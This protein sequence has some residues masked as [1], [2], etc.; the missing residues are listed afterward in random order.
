MQAL[1]D[2][3]EAAPSQDEMSKVQI[4]DLKD[5][6]AKAEE[7][8]G[9][10]NDEYQHLR[11]D[12]RLKDETIQQLEIEISC[13]RGQ[14]N[15]L[16]KFCDETLNIEPEIEQ[17][18]DDNDSDSSTLTQINEEESSDEVLLEDLEWDNSANVLEDKS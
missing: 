9:Q 14:V 4:A 7:L 12:L 15:A 6:L 16:Q 1:V 3:M 17:I 8:V 5:E 10:R 2:Q 18:L 11:R 13:L